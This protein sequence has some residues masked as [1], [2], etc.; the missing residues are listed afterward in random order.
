MD[1]VAPE[2]VLLTLALLGPNLAIRA[3]LKEIDRA[4]LD[5][6]GPTA[7]IGRADT[8]LDLV[9]GY[10]DW[11]A[12][13]EQCETEGI[14]LFA[15]IEQLTPEDDSL[16]EEVGCYLRAVA[17][18]AVSVDFDRPIP[19]QLQPVINTLSIGATKHQPLLSL[20][21]ARD[22]LAEHLI[23]TRREI[24]IEL[25]NAQRKLDS[26]RSRISTLAD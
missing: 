7:T 6:S 25:E 26:S 14:Q 4:R 18:L 21:R 20:S 9:R 23:D 3:L 24:C 17:Q 8:A 16:T 19:T 10:M 11:T 12:S 22:A 2:E 15:F 1:T 13:K 5:L